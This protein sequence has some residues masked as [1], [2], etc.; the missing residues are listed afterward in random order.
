MPRSPISLAGFALLLVLL[1][2]SPFAVQAQIRFDGLE[3]TVGYYAWSGQDFRDVEGGPRYTAGP[4]ARLG[5]LWQLGLEGYYGES[6]LRL[7]TNPVSLDEYGINLV[8]RRAFGSL[9]GAHFFVLG[10]AGWTRLTS[11]IENLQTGEVTTGLSQDGFAFGPEI[12]A[13]F[14]PSEYL[15]VVWALGANWESF[16]ECQVFGPDDFTTG[17][18]CSGVRWGVRIGI[19]LGRTN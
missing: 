3:G 1:G 4:M 18:S 15:D 5:E 6:E 7:Q 12:G 19:A 14:K 16:G 10:R 9:V 17:N 13:G 2:F 11:E 8:A